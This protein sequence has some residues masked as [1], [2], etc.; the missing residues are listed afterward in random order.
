[1]NFHRC[2]ACGDE[3]QPR[4]DGA[5]LLQLAIL[6]PKTEVGPKLSPAGEDF[7]SKL[8]GGV[9]SRTEEEQYKFDLCYECALSM[10][11]ALKKQKADLRAGRRPV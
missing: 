2:D 7:M 9:S 6:A 11:V 10:A 5:G 3:Y 8:L 4:P 1:M